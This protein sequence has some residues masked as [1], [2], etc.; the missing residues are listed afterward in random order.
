[1]PKLGRF[2]E[3]VSQEEAA[4]SAVD[5]TPKDPV[6]P[7][8]L[9]EP[10]EIK[11]LD[12]S[13]LVDAEGEGQ[14]REFQI[15]EI[16]NIQAAL[17]EFEEVLE[18][19]EEAGGLHPEEAEM[20]N[21]GMEHFAERLGV[22]FTK[23]LPSLEDYANGMTRK[24][25]LTVSQEM[26][27]VVDKALIDKAIEMVKKLIAKAKE[28]ISKLDLQTG[29][30]DKLLG[31]VKA[32]YRKWRTG[33]VT[34]KS[35]M[36][37]MLRDEDLT[38]EGLKA[39]ADAGQ[40]SM[41]LLYHFLAAAKTATRLHA[42]VLLGSAGEEDDINKFKQNVRE[43]WGEQHSPFVLALGQ[44]RKE[45]KIGSAT[46]GRLKL[47]FPNGTADQYAMEFITDYG[48][49]RA[50]GEAEVTMTKAEFSNLLNTCEALNNAVKKNTVNYKAIITAAV[51]LTQLA[52][53]AP[54][55]NAARAIANV[56]DAINYMATVELE[57]VVRK[58]STLR[59][60]IGVFLLLAGSEFDKAGA[61]VDV[62]NNK[63]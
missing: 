57:N 29:K 10:E 43:V 20:L 8:A 12:A 23:T 31:D 59:N 15:K 16:K 40:F 63:A 17:E 11:D 1:M 55:Q 26:L 60:G 52:A 5:L 38:P 2:I 33:E 6:V 62:A 19:A 21:V 61:S 41:N 36:G 18:G 45:I 25:A 51:E 4:A 53:K 44:G 30:V 27:V 42:N 32:R 56:G 49:G 7:E 14:T 24:G 3:R 50:S 47:E 58:V 46:T 34:F 54:S 13:C 9:S 39:V 37:A 22:K 28:F 48:G 35:R